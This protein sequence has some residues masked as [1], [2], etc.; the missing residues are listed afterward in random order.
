M[1]SV[2]LRL[3]GSFEALGPDGAPIELSGKKIQALVAYLAV[4]EKR[5]HSRDELATLLWGQM[6]DERARHNLRQAL[7]KLRRQCDSIAEIEDDFIRVDRAQCDID[8]RELE[9]LSSASDPEALERAVDLYRGDFL[10]GFSTKEPDFDDWLRDTR[11]RLRNRASDVFGRLAEAR[12]ERGELEQAMELHRRRLLMDPACE[13]AHRGLMELLARTGRRSDALRQYQS[14]VD[15]L[16][17]ELG[18]E[19]SSETKSAYAKILGTE[20]TE[21][22]PPSS[23]PTSPAFAESPDAASSEPPS[24]AVLPFENLSG[25]EQAYFADGITEDITTALSRFRSL[26]VIARASAYAF[27]DRNLTVQEIGRELGAQFV[28]QGS[29]RRAGTQARINV[30]LVDASTGRHVWAQRFDREL[31]DVLLVQDEVTATIVSTLAGRVEASRMAQARRMPSERLAAYDFVLRGKDHHHRYTPDDCEK[32]IDM[33]ERAIERDPDYA[34]AHAW[35][36]CGLGQAR[37][38]RPEENEALIARAEEAAQR[39]RQL[40]HE[41]AECYRVLAN[42]AILRCDPATAETYQE[43]GL[44]LNP[45]DDRAVAAMG[46]IHCFRGRHE[47]SVEWIRRAMRLNPYHPESLW[48]YLGRALFHAGRY[49]ETIEAIGKLTKTSATALAYAAAASVRIGDAEAIERF[50]KLLLETNPSFDPERFARRL[51]YEREGDRRAL[52]DA[53]RTALRD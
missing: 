6:G 44:A 26:F 18:A 35:L 47:E 51:P 25:D 40:D 8:V 15:A 5:S 16:E 32:A 48:L 38:Y 53:L 22:E 1:A 46:Q 21:A 33:F 17:R 19:P 13:P 20:S 9:E 29:V 14:C 52:I 34:V 31:E 7:S 39:A 45:N 36:A 24:V 4:E 10:E 11:A 23:P 49:Q 50:T 12:T 43:R 41:E 28:V 2:R 27:R 3:L 37:A 42:V 30:Q